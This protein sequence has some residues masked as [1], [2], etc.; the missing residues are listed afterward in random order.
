MFAAW[1]ESKI[2]QSKH[3]K[4]QLERDSSYL[5]IRTGHKSLEQNYILT[6]FLAHRS[7]NEPVI[8]ESVS[9]RASF[10]FLKRFNLLRTFF[11]WTRIW[12][13]HSST[14]SVNSKKISNGAVGRFGRHNKKS[15]LDWQKTWITY[16]T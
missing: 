14:S 10:S 12:F 3:V 5:I 4:M 8:S 1:I 13:W 9:I 16:V 2:N 7:K 6:L 15:E 11:A